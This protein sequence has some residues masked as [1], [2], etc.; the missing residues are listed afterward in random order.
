MFNTATNQKYKGPYPD[1]RMYD[2]DNMHPKKRDEIIEWHRENVESGAVFDFEKEIL[3]Y[4]WEDVHIFLLCSISF[5]SLV[6][7]IAKFCPFNDCITIAS[8]CMRL[9]KSSFLQENAIGLIPPKGY[10]HTG[11]QSEIALK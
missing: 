6:V 8:V 9:F 4:C 11:T 7:K 5:R 2:V 1:I 10:R 3:E